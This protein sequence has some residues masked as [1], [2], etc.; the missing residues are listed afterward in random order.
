APRID[1]SA[2]KTTAVRGLGEATARDVASPQESSH[3]LRAFMR[4]SPGADRSD[5]PWR[6]TTDRLQRD[7][8][9][10][11]AALITLA[12]RLE[13]L[14]EEMAGATVAASPTSHTSVPTTLEPVPAAYDEDE[15]DESP[16]ILSLPT[17]LPPRP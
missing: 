9:S 11:N 8:A 14:T 5:E 17:S 10:I 12:E 7:I 1:G 3:S 13:A 6:K 15:W 4:A 2:T 16:K